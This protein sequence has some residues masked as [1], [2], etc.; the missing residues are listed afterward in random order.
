MPWF[1]NAVVCLLFEKEENNMEQLLNSSRLFPETSVCPMPCAAGRS[2]LFCHTESWGC[3]NV[4]LA[5][6]VMVEGSEE[7][8]GMASGEPLAFLILYW[9]L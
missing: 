7:S 9:L 6:L 2:C 4:A 1:E 8:A 5:F 3:L